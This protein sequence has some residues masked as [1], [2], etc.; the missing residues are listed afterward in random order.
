MITLHFV[1]IVWN[2][3]PKELNTSQEHSDCNW[4]QV[5]NLFISEQNDSVFVNL[6]M[7]KLSSLSYIY[8]CGINVVNTIGEDEDKEIDVRTVKI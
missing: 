3:L 4:S 5:Y 6:V 7:E 2:G 1:L 8:V